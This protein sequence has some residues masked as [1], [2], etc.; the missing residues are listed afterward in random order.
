M[1]GQD[2]RGGAGERG[3]Q[4]TDVEQALPEILGLPG[5]GQFA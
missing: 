2:L 3:V 5:G 1:G 4:K